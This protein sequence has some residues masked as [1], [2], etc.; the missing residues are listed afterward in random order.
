MLFSK[1]NLKLKKLLRRIKRKLKKVFIGETTKS[2]T[3]KKAPI[4]K[5]VHYI[6][7]SSIKYLNTLKN[8]SDNCVSTVKETLR[9]LGYPMSK[10]TI[11]PSEELNID[12]MYDRYERMIAEY[13]Q[14]LNLKISPDTAYKKFALFQKKYKSQDCFNFAKTDCVVF[15]WDWILFALNRGYDHQDYFDFDS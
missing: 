3:T 1:I 12:Y 6:D 11:F 8:S 9:L 4:K 13:I 14:K 15:Y 2:K 7:Y 5:Q 10:D